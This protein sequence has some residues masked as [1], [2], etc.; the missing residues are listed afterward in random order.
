MKKS[1]SV[2]EYALFISAVLVGLLTMQVYYHRAVKG[3]LKAKTDSIG[4]QFN[5][6]DDNYIL[7]SKSVSGQSIQQGQYVQGA[8]FDPSLPYQKSTISQGSIANSGFAKNLT[9]AGASLSGAYA[10]GEISV[11][12]YKDVVDPSKHGIANMGQINTTGSAFND[13]GM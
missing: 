13:L 12:D 4:E 6:K 5:L 10:G 3:N 1:Q 7:E 2:T 11:A 8:G 9:A